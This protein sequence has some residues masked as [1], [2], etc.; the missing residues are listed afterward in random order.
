[1][2]LKKNDLDF[3]SD[4]FKDFCK[5]NNLTESEGFQIVIDR[6]KELSDMEREKIWFFYGVVWMTDLTGKKVSIYYDDK[7]NYN[8]VAKKDG[9]CIEDTNYKIVIKNTSG[10]TEIIPYSRIIRI[11]EVPGEKEWKRKQLPNN[12]RKLRRK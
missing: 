1:M 6:I 5:D 2:I 9:L 3:S 7:S 11:I 12:R 10:F 8:T 4:N